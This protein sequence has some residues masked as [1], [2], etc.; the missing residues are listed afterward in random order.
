MDNTGTHLFNIL[1]I[2][3]VHSHILSV[4]SFLVNLNLKNVPQI[5][6]NNL[7]NNLQLDYFQ[8]HRELR[9]TKM[10]VNRS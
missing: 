9:G 8:A 5:S 4:L 7:I 10:A 3:I 6:Q 2:Y 1:Y